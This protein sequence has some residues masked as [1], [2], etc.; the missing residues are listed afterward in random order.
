M[1]RNFQ[2]FN[3]NNFRPDPKPEKVE[4]KKPTKIKPLSDKR[5]KQN[6]VYLTV[7]KVYLENHP[8]CE[9]KLDGCTGLSTEIHHTKKRTGELLCDVRYFKATCRN[10]H[11]IVE[12]NNIKM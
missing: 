1:Q 8:E 7:R 10:C 5:S 4:K 9:I 6:K 11:T 12:N 3:A 2:K